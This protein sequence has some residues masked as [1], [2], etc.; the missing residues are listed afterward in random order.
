MVQ[1]FIKTGGL[2]SRP[3]RLARKALPILAINL[4]L[5]NSHLLVFSLGEPHN[6]TRSFIPRATKYCKTTN[7]LPNTE[8]LSSSLLVAHLLWLLLIP[9]GLPGGRFKC[10]MA[11]LDCVGDGTYHEVG[12]PDT[13]QCNLK[14]KKKFFVLRG[15][16]IRHILPPTHT[17][18]RNRG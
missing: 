13:N 11:H 3:A 16:D 8:P 1:L 7:M 9:A 4:L 18:L 10:P 14:Q 6:I 2:H 17:R 15:I 12:R 5:H